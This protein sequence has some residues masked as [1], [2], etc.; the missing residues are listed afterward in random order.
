M[1][2]S[3]IE[4]DLFAGTAQGESLP[5]LRPRAYELARADDT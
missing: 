1:E 2:W 4:H 5:F 3:W